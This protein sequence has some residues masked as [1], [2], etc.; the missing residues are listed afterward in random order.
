MMRNINVLKGKVGSAVSIV[1]I[2]SLS[3]T[4]C[5]GKQ[6]QPVVDTVTVEPNDSPDLP[7]SSMIDAQLTARGIEPV[8][9]GMRIVEIEPRVENLYDTIVREGGYESNSYHFL[10]NGEQRFTVF[11]FESGI[12]NIVAADNESII[13]NGNDDNILRLGDSFTKVFDLKDVK[14]VYQ[15]MDDEGMWCWQ[16]QGIWF[17]PDQQNLNDV[18]V[19]KLYSTSVAPVKS[20]FTDDIKIGYIGTGL[21]W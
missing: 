20:D 3:L 7:E 4:G 13:V 9:V 5:G 18:L 1:S 21:P 17:Q 19:H 14:P 8:K 2:L 16:W 15:S 6:A 10:L 12:A 11:E